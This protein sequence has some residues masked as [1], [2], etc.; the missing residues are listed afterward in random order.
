MLFRSQRDHTRRRQRRAHP[1]A[2]RRAGR[3]RDDGAARPTPCRCAHDLERRAPGQ[4][5]AR[6]GGQQHR[7]PDRVDRGRGA[8]CLGGR[9]ALVVEH[10]SSL[11]SPAGSRQTRTGFSQALVRGEDLPVHRSHPDTDVPAPADPGATPTTGRTGHNAWRLYR[12]A[13]PSP[14]HD[15]P[16]P[17]PVLLLHGVTDSGECWPGTVRHLVRSRDVLALD[18]S[19]ERRVGTECPV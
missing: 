2:L 14:A 4:R 17:P 8:S 16:Q 15:A 6:R 9:G 10:R 13:T 12:T 18:R 1:D 5:H 11:P 3:S 19:E 7:T